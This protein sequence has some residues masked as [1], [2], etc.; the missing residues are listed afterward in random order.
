MGEMIDVVDVNDDVIGSATREDVYLKKLRHR[1]VHVLVFDNQENIA[2][3]LRS[4]KCSFCPHYWSSSAGGHVKSKES[5]EKAALRE[6]EEEI[7]ISEDLEFFS[8]DI[9]KK[10]NLPEKIIVVFKCVFSGMF[11]I[12]KREVEKIKFFSVDEIKKM[13]KN[14]ERF[15]PELLFLLKKYFNI[16][17]D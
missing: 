5:Y 17:Q 4:K 1:I 3:Q 9:Y 11:N 6:L 13:I 10:K 14:K 15:H 8:K 2:L 12:N 7:G 16:V